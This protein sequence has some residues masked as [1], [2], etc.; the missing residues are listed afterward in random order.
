MV[1]VAATSTSS[2]VFRKS[3]CIGSAD[4]TSGPDHVADSS[5]IEAK[6]TGA[7]PAQWES[8]VYNPGSARYKQYGK[9]ADILKQA[10]NLLGLARGLKKP[11]GVVYAVSNKEGYGAFTKLFKKHFPKEL[12]SRFL[13]VFFVPPV[14]MP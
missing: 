11:R 13:R 2:Q 9:E 8:S 7:N 10:K 5:I 4:R 14:G 1:S 6:W 3:S 12:Q